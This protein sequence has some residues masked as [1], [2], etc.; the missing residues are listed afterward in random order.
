MTHFYQING[1]ERPCRFGFS[2]LY[3]YEINTGH[4]A[5]DDFNALG[6]S[7]EG[8]SVKLVVNLAYAGFLCGHRHEKKAVDFNDYHVAD[9]LTP[10]LMEKVLNDFGASFPKPTEGEPATEPHINDPKKKD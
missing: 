10:E 4:S 8:I 2:A 3:Q 9:W 6:G 1:E 5:M 7:T